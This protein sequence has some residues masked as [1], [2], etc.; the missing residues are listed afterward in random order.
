MLSVKSDFYRTHGWGRRLWNV[1]MGVSTSSRRHFRRRHL[2][3]KM[4]TPEMT[5]SRTW[6]GF[7]D[8]YC[9]GGGKWRPFRFRS[10][11]WMTSFPVNEVIQDGDRK[12]KGRH[13]PPPPQ[14]GSKNPPYTTNLAYPSITHPKFLHVNDNRFYAG[15][16][17]VDLHKGNEMQHL[18]HKVVYTSCYRQLTCSPVLWWNSIYIVKSTFFSTSN[19]HCIGWGKHAHELL[20]I[21]NE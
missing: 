1:F 10:P 3:S 21:L 4:A 6:G 2:G 14:W 9:G 20:A 12:R 17:S 19:K 18:R 13:S 15:I 8:P 5:S 11:S 16:S 7:F